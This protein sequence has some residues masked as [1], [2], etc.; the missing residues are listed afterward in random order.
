[1]YTGTISIGE[2]EI[3]TI[4]FPKPFSKPPIVIVS[5]GCVSI[6]PNQDYN[7]N[8]TEHVSVARA[9]ETEV[10]VKW[11]SI[12]QSNLNS[13]TISWIAIGE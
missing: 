2:S 7:K 10:K 11:T 6:N 4:N 8:D 12:S 13:R 9:T 5:I 3:L 1:M